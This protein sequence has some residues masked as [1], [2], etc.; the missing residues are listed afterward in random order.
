MLQGYLHTYFIAA[1]F[2]I[3]IYK[4]LPPMEG[5]YILAD[6]FGEWGWGD[7]KRGREN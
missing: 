5:G 6:K 3:Y 2:F 4:S 1:G 7:K